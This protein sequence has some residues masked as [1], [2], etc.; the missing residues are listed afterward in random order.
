MNMFDKLQRFLLD[1]PSEEI[2]KSW[3]K[4]K[5]NDHNGYLMDDVLCS[6]TDS[7]EKLPLEE[8]QASEL[9]KYKK[10]PKFS[11]FFF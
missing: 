6:L 5:N 1:T 2:I 10:T 3:N 4:I 11:E 8:E 7:F 9:L